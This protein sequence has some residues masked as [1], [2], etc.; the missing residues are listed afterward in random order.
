MSLITD[1]RSPLPALPV[2][3]VV[4]LFEPR[5]SRRMNPLIIG[6]A[7]AGIPCLLFPPS[8]VLD[9]PVLLPLAKRF[10]ATLVLR[11]LGEASLG[12]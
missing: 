3:V 7:L 12:P 1:S 2:E 8:T 5:G 11:T 10:P 4:R 9:L 6:L